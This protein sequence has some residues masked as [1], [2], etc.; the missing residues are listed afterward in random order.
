MKKQMKANSLSKTLA[1]ALNAQMNKKVD[2]SQIYLNYALWA[3]DRGFECLAKLLFK[4]AQEEHNHVMKI[5]KFILNRGAEIY[6]TAII[7]P[8]EE[9]DSIDNFFEKIF[10][11]EVDITK[12]FYNLTELSL[13]EE[14]WETLRFMKGF[15]NGQTVEENLSTG[16][17][18]KMDKMKIAACDK[19]NSYAL[20]SLDWDFVNITEGALSA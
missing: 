8:F 17:L 15:V 2:A 7:V 16:L 14:D 6:V 11:Y 4:Y 1:S 10:E 12:A 13:N 20:F 18:D 5:L 3:E 19:L 9:P